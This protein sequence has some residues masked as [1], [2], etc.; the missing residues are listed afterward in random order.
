[1]AANGKTAEAEAYLA[2]GIDDAKDVR[3]GLVLGR[4]LGQQ[5][6]TEDALRIYEQMRVQF[7][8]HAPA[9]LFCGIALLDL[10]RVDDAVAAIARTL[11]LQPQNDVAL[12]YLAL[13]R[14]IQGDDEGA[15]RGFRRD[16]VSDNRM[17]RVRLTEWMETEW[18][19]KGR[20]FAQQRLGIATDK[21]PAK[22]STR[23]AQKHFYAK[24]YREMLTELE[25]ASRAD[26]PDQSILFACALGA[27]M[28]F[29]YERAL[30][31]LSRVKDSEAEWPDALTA[32]RGRSLVRLGD[33][34]RGA[35]DLGR[36]LTVGPEDFG[37]NY[38]LGVLCL[39]HGE[40][41]QARQLFLRAH[42]QYL[43]DTLDFQY[44]QMERALGIGLQAR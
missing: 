5:G 1:M 11:E 44:W 19:G 28:L 10:R 31:Y 38:Y 36:V 14:L 4:I 41:H 18:L 16:G 8:Q 26:N 35:A 2:Q 6:R 12:S 21:V 9:H 20:F 3:Q 24:R 13:S 37:S 30:D 42:T 27:E 29:D 33:F 40:R 15:L 34:A 25:S 43:I 39:A 7:P 23:R 22:T 17:F 32:A